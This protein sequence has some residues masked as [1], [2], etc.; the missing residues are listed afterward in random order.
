MNFSELASNSG[1]DESQLV[2]IVHLFV[3]VTDADLD[4][5]QAAIQQGIVGQVIEAAHSIKGAAANFGFK[6][7]YEAARDIE[8]N[9]RSNHLQG[10]P[11]Q[12]RVIRENLDIIARGLKSISTPAEDAVEHK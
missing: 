6:N 8:A 12:I 10:V 5:L 1:L 11:G 9:A 7:I 4:R 3:Q 2:T